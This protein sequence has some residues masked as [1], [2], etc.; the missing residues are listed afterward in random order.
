MWD[1]WV[2]VGRVMGGG[3]QNEKLAWREPGWDLLPRPPHGGANQVFV[4]GT[5]AQGQQ[6]PGQVLPQPKSRLLLGRQCSPDPLLSG[7]SQPHLPPRAP[8]VNPPEATPLPPQARCASGKLWTRPGPPTGSATMS[9]GLG[10]WLLRAPSHLPVQRP[11]RQSPSQKPTLRHPPGRA[12][13]SALPRVPR[14]TPPGGSAL[15]TMVRHFRAPWG[16]GEAS[17]RMRPFSELSLGPILPSS[18][19]SS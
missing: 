13:A 1:H 12:V 3:G 10:C 7:S 19:P 15:G 5:Q 18:L 17:A 11:A 16:S 2:R 6:V 8:V 9:T 4:K 14:P